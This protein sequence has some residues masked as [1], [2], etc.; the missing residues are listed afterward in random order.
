M[1]TSLLKD[2]GTT[3]SGTIGAQALAL[4]SLPILT[5]MLEPEAFGQLQLYQSLI[6][7]S[8]YVVTLRYEVALIQ[9]KSITQLITV[10]K[11][12][13]VVAIITSLLAALIVAIVS[14]SADIPGDVKLVLWM[15]P[16]GMLLTGGVNV[17]TYIFARQRMFMLG[18]QAK[19]SQSGAFA[20]G[21]IT[22]ASFLPTAAALLYA[23]ILARFAYIALALFVIPARTASL[24]KRITSKQIR[25]AAARLRRY[26]LRSV[27]S[28][29]INAAGAMAT[30]V[31]IYNIFG[32]STA[33]QYALVER[34]MLMPLGMIT[35]SLSQ[36]A[37][38]RL[39]GYNVAVSTGTMLLFKQVIVVS[40][41]L[42]IVA[43]AAVIALGP[44]LFSVVFGN[45]WQIAGRYA[46]VMS[47]LIMVSLV[48]GP[49]NMSLLVLGR[50]T[51]QL[52]W[53]TGRLS[54][55]AV[56]W[57]IIVYLDLDATIALSLLACANVAAVTVFVVLVY[58][59]LRHPHK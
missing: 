25:Q 16:C 59:A 35:V 42:G 49:I 12:C 27:P 29:L 22:V 33:G 47:P 57:I 18:A 17:L 41:L 36:V 4:V 44:S 6:L 20:V 28:G 10:T 3:I 32:A 51:Q 13:V 19:I 54:L 5:R 55:L 24:L 56:V 7:F 11:L 53:D 31:M 23:D 2:S 30:P 1:K 9:T 34:V 39:V 8:A 40:V 26:P 48:M 21:S 43:M 14:A 37:M 50:Q 15:F 58:R 46:Q 52:C 38:S 45:D